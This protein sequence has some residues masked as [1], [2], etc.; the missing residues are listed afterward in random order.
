MAKGQSVGIYMTSVY[1]DHVKRSRYLE[2]CTYSVFI[3]LFSDLRV[4]KLHQQT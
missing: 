4:L 2:L 3:P 1:D